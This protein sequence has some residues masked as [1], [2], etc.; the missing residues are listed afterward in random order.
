MILFRCQRWIFLYLVSLK[1]NEHTHQSYCQVVS[2]WLA[3]T[4]CELT[5]APQVLCALSPFKSLDPQHSI[6]IN[7]TERMPWWLIDFFTDLASSSVWGRTSEVMD[8]VAPFHLC[9]FLYVCVFVCVARRVLWR[10]TLR[11]CWRPSSW[12][13]WCLP[14]TSPCCKPAPR[15]SLRPR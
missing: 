6:A 3:L 11:W 15:P 4:I 10:T 9:L 8:S 2:Y 5:N 1:S 7:R 12:S 13:S 14:T